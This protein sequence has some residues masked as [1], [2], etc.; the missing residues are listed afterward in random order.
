MSDT[1]VK[2][3]SIVKNAAKPEG[4]S[5]RFPL[6]EYDTDKNPQKDFMNPYTYSVEPPFSFT[7]ASPTSLLSVTNDP[8]SLGRFTT[9][10]I[11]SHPHHFGI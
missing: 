10:I 9:K 7:I 3:S 2:N 11:Y 8:L 4:D 5:E 1:C 6:N